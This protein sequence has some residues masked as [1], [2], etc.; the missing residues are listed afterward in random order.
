MLISSSDKDR[1]I[2]AEVFGIDKEKVK[3]TGLPR[4][5]FLFESFEIT[6]EIEKKLQEIKQNK[7]LVLYA[8][9]LRE[10]IKDPLEQIT[11]DEWE[12]IDSF[13]KENDIVF[14]VRSHYY[15][16]HSFNE[17]VE[18]FDNIVLLN[19]RDFFETN[20][21]LKHTDLLISD[22]SS[23]WIDYLLLNRPIIGF[24]KDFE[25]FMENER[26]FLYDFDSTFPGKFAKSV[27]EML[28]FIKN[29]IGKTIEY[30]QKR[31]FHKY[32]SGF[33]KNVFN[34]VKKLKGK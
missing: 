10:K 13:A 5:E 25:H 7:S 1:E 3:V 2:M 15:E 26:G 33:S 17:T 29:D 30:P 12:K 8:P 34:E 31:L 19:H 4:Y 28:E 27:D 22:F 24:A 32:E 16:Q 18:K 9:T 14:A 23:I 11:Q 6:K 21:I 20:T